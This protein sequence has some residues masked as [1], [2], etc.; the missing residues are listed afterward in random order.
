MASEKTFPV[1]GSLI[2]QSTVSADEVSGL[3][4]CTLWASAAGLPTGILPNSQSESSCH[5]LFMTLALRGL[6][7]GHAVSSTTFELARAM[8]I[9]A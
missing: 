7:R 4:S 1:H 3:H 6:I 9:S 5:G 2:G 8:P